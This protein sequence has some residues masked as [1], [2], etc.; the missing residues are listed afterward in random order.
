MLLSDRDLLAAIDAGRLGLS[1]FDKALIQPSSIDVRLDRYFR[2]FANHRYTHID[3]A[4]QQ[5][6]LTEL[7]EPAGDEPF[8]LHPGEFVL[9]STLEVISLGDDLASRL[10]GKALALD[11]EVP[12]PWGWTRMEYLE[13]GDEVFDQD[14]NPT[15]VVATTDPM[16][17]RQCYEIELS[18]GSRFVADAQ[19]QWVTFTKSERVRRKGGRQP[20]PT[21]KT[22]EELAATLRAGK[23]WNHHIPLAGPAVYE[24]R[25]DLPVDPYV[26][27]VW[28]G[29]GTT[30]KAEITDS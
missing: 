24:E 14:G 5:D 23:E 26:L 1:P 9:G 19:H 2:V 12:T 28:L 30:S 4:Q 11:T 7:V 20:E 29:D 18:D 15:Q 3:P 13:V 10:E 6:D 17:D 25:T 16:T 8:I 27:G 21:S 22:T